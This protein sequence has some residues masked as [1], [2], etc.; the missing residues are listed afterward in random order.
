MEDFFI[1]FEK[2]AR[3]ISPGNIKALADTA[4]RKVT[5]KPA[6]TVDLG[7]YWNASAPKIP[8]WKIK[9]QGSNA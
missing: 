1:G 9:M 4:K 3:I 5:R 6:G 2:Q 8:N 7:D